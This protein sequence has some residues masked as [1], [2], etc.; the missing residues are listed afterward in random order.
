MSYCEMPRRSPRKKQVQILTM[1]VEEKSVEEKPSWKKMLDELYA[2]KARNGHCNVSQNDEPAT[3]LGHWVGH[4]RVLYKKN[5]LRSNQIQQLHSVGFIWDSLE[6]HA[7][8]E[9]FN[10]LCAF[11]AQNGHCN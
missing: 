5:A 4:Q 10:Q 9:K 1:S 6:H 11:K 8:N 2:F 7:W 3:S